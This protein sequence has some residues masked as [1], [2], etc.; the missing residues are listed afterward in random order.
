[1]STET[2]RGVV[3]GAGG[4]SGG[5]LLRLLACHPN[6]TIE[7]ALSNT[8]AGKSVSDIYPNLAP[9]TDAVFTAPDEWPMDRLATGCW[10]LFAAMPHVKTMSVLGPLVKKFDNP[11]LKVVDLSGDFRLD[12]PE[13]YRTFYKHDHVAEDLLDAFVYGLPEIHREAIRKARLVANPGCFATGCQL[14]L[15]PVAA[16]GENASFVAVDAKTGSSGGGIRPAGTSHHPNRMNNFSAYKQLSH[17]HFPEIQG[18]WISAGGNQETVISFVPQRAPI[19]RGIFVTAHFMMD[20]ATDQVEA[21]GW[22][23]EYYR[24]HPFVRIVDSSP[25]VSNIW[26]TNMCDISV[27]AKGRVVVA[28]AAIDNLLK[29][30]SGQAVQNANLMNGLEETA[31]LLTP[32]PTPI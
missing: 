3:Y 6:F 2:I 23:R 1:M 9:W 20:G 17:Q 26:G 16:S 30:A 19:V 28:S 4:F 31:G 10:T 21:E 24:G 11:E 15:L 14:A 7:A 8:H 13:T 12:D 27:T 32:A 5:E 18:G 29:G 25:F 22:Y